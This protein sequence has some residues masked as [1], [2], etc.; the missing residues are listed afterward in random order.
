MAS[1]SSDTGKLE[2]A[3]LWRSIILSSIGGT[4]YP[5]C[6]YVRT[7]SL[8]L[9]F[10]ENMPDN[11]NDK[12]I[13][14]FFFEGPMEP[15]LVLL[16]GTTPSRK[17]R[18]ARISRIHAEKTMVKCADSVT[19]YIKKLADDTETA[20]ALAHLEFYNVPIDLLP[21]WISRLGTL[22]SL[23]IRDGS[24]L[25]AEAG[26]AISQYCPHFDDLTLY[27]LEGPTVDEDMAA[28]FR[29]LRPNSLRSFEIMSQNRIGEETLTALNT[30]ASSLKCLKLGTLSAQAMKCLNVLPSCTALEILEIENEGGSQVDLR[31]FSEQMLKEV[32]AWIQ[33]CKS[34]RELSFRGVQDALLIV[35]DV[36][37]SP[38]IHLT[39]L[40]IQFLRQFNDQDSA[41]TWA[42]L[43]MQDSLES[44]TLGAKLD[45]QDMFVLAEY[46]PL[47]ES[48]C[49]LKNLKSLNL[50]QTFAQAFE[51]HQ[52]ARSLPN[53]VD[54]SFGGEL[55]DDTILTSLAALPHLMAVG[56]N[57][58]SAFT[59]P[60]LRN[61]AHKLELARRYGF[62]C[63]ILG[64]LGDAK[65]S[66]DQQNWLQDFFATALYGRFDVGYYMDPD[67]L[68]E[69]D[70]SDLSD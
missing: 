3:R 40:D 64:Q 69:D 48:I 28:F 10:V 27:W 67:E 23:R 49:R 4:A 53:L 59:W 17:T 7:L 14:D 46:P 35:K 12:A 43:E 54:F 68:H 6:A 26:S 47:A 56:I 31:A 16:E 45:Q 63:E 24:I 20:V 22:T 52:F 55:M 66:A 19:S 37:T 30:H 1:S 34:L 15:F 8:G 38:D 13:R 2:W 9:N 21:T 61:F 39:S 5:Y 44:L 33:S 50:K 18:G 36:L 58:Q 70:F 25:G 62:Q 51:I 29:T 57:A 11:L 32:T 42:A 65:F 60:G 41:A